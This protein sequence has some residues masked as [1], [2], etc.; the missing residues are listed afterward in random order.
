MQSDLALRRLAA[1]AQPTRLAL[2]R[3]LLRRGNAGLSAACLMAEFGIGGTA[4]SFHLK[5]LLRAGLIE[6][7]SGPDGLRYRAQSSALG[8]LLEA[9]AAE[10]CIEAE[11]GCGLDRLSNPPTTAT[12]AVPLRTQE[13][14][15]APARTARP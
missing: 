7:V 3:R 4:L 12:L 5:A 8:E 15:H 10:C 14:L 6:G 2:F 11:R 1:L 13:P 9:I